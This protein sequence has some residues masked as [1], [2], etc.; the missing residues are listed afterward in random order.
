M[1]SAAASAPRTSQAQLQRQRQRQRSRQLAL[2]LVLLLLALFY[3]L[4][5]IIWIASASFDPR[6]SLVNL[7]LIPQG[8]TLDNYETLLNSDIHPFTRWLWN[9]IKV[10]TITMVLS[11]LVS[12]FAAY[13]FSRFRFRGRDATLLT[14]FLIQVFPNSL[15]IVATFLLIQEIGNYIPSLGLNSHGG[16]ILV[17]LGGALG[18]N[19]WLMKGFF[20]SVPRDLDE[21]A[22]IDGASDWRIFWQ[23]LF[24]LVRPILAV[25][26][27]LTFISTYND[28]IIALTLLK[29][30]QQQTLAVGLNLFLGEQFSQQW[31]VFAAGALIGA[32]P[33]VVLY[34]LMQDYIVGGLTAGAVKG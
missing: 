19:T 30:T 15:T 12:T 18:I 33:I 29:N 17:Y 20:D 13:A 3:A 6:N 31:G 26:G 5:P 22:M 28:V 7:G 8:A 21:S 32:V 11:V 27:I 1:S 14:V 9:S 16:L 2:R 25:V 24:P 4:F 34:L 10:S 23:I